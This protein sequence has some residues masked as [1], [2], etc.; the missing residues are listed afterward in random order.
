MDDW[1]SLTIARDRERGACETAHKV[2]THSFFFRSFFRL[3][4]PNQLS[5]KMEMSHRHDRE[6]ALK[7]CRIAI[8]SLRNKI[9]Q[10]LRLGQEALSRSINKQKPNKSNHVAESL[11]TKMSA[12]QKF[13]LFSKLSLR[14]QVATFSPDFCF[15]EEFMYYLKGNMPAAGEIF[16]ILHFNMSFLSLFSWYYWLSSCE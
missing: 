9:T 14:R 11:K 6:T 16:E 15:K 12:W 3:E 4:N 5:W 13:D 2:G 8:R 1:K 10:E 7:R